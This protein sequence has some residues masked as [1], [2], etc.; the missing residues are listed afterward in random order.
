M[1]ARDLCDTL[2]AYRNRKQEDKLFL[3]W[4]ITSGVMEGITGTGI[5]LREYKEHLKPV[6]NRSSAAIL[7][8]VSEIIDVFNDTGMKQ[9]GVLDGII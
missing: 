9:V 8:E 1:D 6:D 2:I 3:R 5:S 4:A 7:K